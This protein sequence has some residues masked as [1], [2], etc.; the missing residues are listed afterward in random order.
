MWQRETLNIFNLFHHLSVSSVHVW[1]PNAAK[2]NWS[3]SDTWWSERES[4]VLLMRLKTEQRHTLV[5]YQWLYFT[6]ESEWIQNM[7]HS[8]HLHIQNHLKDNQ[9]GSIFLWR[10]YQSRAD[11][12]LWSPTISFWTWF[13]FFTCEGTT[14]RYIK[15]NW[16]FTYTE[17]LIQR[18]TCIIL[19]RFAE[20]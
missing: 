16:Q 11:S 9:R 20:F 7:W 3:Q 13:T 1:R 12:R 19:Y 8:E 4:P 14:G 6:G 18:E 5:H 15:P 10:W 2:R 17:E